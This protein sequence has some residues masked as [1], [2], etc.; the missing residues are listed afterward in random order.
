MAAQTDF[1]GDIAP[2][3]VR[4]PVAIL[5]E[6][7]SLLGTKTENLIEAA[8]ETGI[9]QGRF[10]HRFNLVVPALDNYTYQLFRIEHGIDLYPLRVFDK[11]IL[12]L[13]TEDDFVDWLRNRLS[14]DDTKKII[15][16]LLAQVNS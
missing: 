7:A 1:W 3:T 14:S 2:A 13:N 12:G 15:G 8:V 10:Q 16:N 9:S 5:R 6:Q 4:T 11:E